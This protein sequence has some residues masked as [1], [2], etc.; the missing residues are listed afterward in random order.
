MFTGSE[1]IRTTP[2]PSPLEVAWRAADEAGERH[3]FPPE[4]SGELAIA[5]CGCPGGPNYNE[6][7]ARDCAGCRSVLRLVLAG[8]LLATR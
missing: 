6:H 1:T 2:P 7:G 8:R 4:A 3:A 5:L